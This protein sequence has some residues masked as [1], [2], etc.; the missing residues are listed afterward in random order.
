MKIR[1]LFSVFAMLLLVS[2]K[3]Q[4]TTIGLIGSATPGGWGADTNMVQDAVNPD[5][6][7]LD[8]LLTDGEAKFRANDA[9]AQN[10]GNTDFPL[11]VGTQ[12]GPNIPVRA[13]MHHV[14][15]NSATGGYYFS[16]VSDIG[17]IG[18]ASLFGWDSDVNMYQDMGDP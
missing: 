11:G 14:T 3:A 2:L 7:S 5:L 8:V 15:F 18:S 17:I 1:L 13:G 6:W 12:D 4:I 10:W 9:W 16:V